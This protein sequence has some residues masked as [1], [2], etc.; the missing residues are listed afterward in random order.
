MNLRDLG[1]IYNKTVEHP[2]NGVGT[3]DNLYAIYVDNKVSFCVEVKYI[4]NDKNIYGLFGI[5]LLKGEIT[6]L[7]YYKYLSYLQQIIKIDSRI[8]YSNIYKMLKNR[9]YDKCRLNA[10]DCFITIDDDNDPESCESDSYFEL[11]DNGIKIKPNIAILHTSGGLSTSYVE[12]NE[13]N[14][15]KN[16]FS[17]IDLST[18]VEIFIKYSD[19]Y[20]SEFG[21]IKKIVKQDKTIGFIIEPV[22]TTLL[23]NIIPGNLNFQN[24]T[25]LEMV[26]VIMNQSK[27]TKLAN[28][29]PDK[30]LQKYRYI[31]FLQNVE[32][33]KDELIIGEMILS[34][35]IDDVSFLNMKMP[36]NKFVYVSIYTSAKNIADAINISQKK[37]KNIL[38]FVELTKKN[39]TFFELYDKKEGITKWDINNLFVDYKVISSYLI[40]NVINP[41]Q[42]IYNDFSAMTLKR[43]ANITDE[44]NI[45]KYHEELEKILFLPNLTVEDLYESIY[46]LNKGLESIN[47]D[48]N[49]SVIYLN[50]AC[51][52]VTKGETGESF[53]DKHPEIKEF[54]KQLK[55]YIKEN[56]AD[57]NTYSEM[58]ESI[59]GALNDTT[60][61]NRFEYMLKRLHLVFSNNEM[62]IYNKMRR[63]RNAIVHKEKK[64]EVFKHDVIIF[65]IMLSKIIFVKMVEKSDENI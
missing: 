36:K 22:E 5:N 32:I 57:K 27:V 45:I 55:K 6:P 47:Y 18:K 39:S 63:A 62:E 59:F 10:L 3:I 56:V 53:M 19:K 15:N 33:N 48:L 28:E 9:K 20:Y 16:N 43:I 58:T 44:D 21:N 24:V 41:K 38:N 29:L 54:K 12:I 17:N 14:Y 1:I 64:V 25:P 52:Y 13:E 8:G 42:I 50:I 2:E 35:R 37:I 30:N 26:S 51:E 4:K 46:W 40:Y 61:P 11:L 49:R 31:T 60:L 65:Y 34:K 7:P 23:N